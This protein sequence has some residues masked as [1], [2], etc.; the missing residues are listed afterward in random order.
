[1]RTQSI[2]SALDEGLRAL[3]LEVFLGELI[4]FFLEGLSQMGVFLSGPLVSRVLLPFVA[5]VAAMRV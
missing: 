4:C 5:V 1:M 3:K 2:R